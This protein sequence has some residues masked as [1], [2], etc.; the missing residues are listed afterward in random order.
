MARDLGT[1]LG[2]A[3]FDVVP[4]LLGFGDS[5]TAGI[6]NAFTAR[7]AVLGD[8]ME[9]A[10]KALFVRFTLP[11]AVA[12]AAN[13]AQFQALE[14][15]VL[16]TLTLF[17]TAPSLIDATFGE[18]SAGIR[19]VAEEV[20]GLERSIADGLYQTISAGV[21]S[22]GAFEFL[23]VAQMAATA[24][25][26]ADLTTAVNALTTGVNAF[27]L[28]WSETQRVSDI[29]FATV[30]RGKTTFGELG[31]DFGR[32]APLAFNAGVRIEETAAII[33]QLT[34]QG[35][36]TSEAVSFLRAAITGLLR[37]GDEMNEIFKAIGFSSAEAAVPVLGLQ[38]AFQ[39]VVDAARGSTSRL[40]E[41]IGTSEG[42][43]AVLGVTGESAAAF[44]SVLR[45]V[46]NSAGSTRRAFEI[47]D[48]SVSRLFGR[49]T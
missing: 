27:G 22:E 11:L 43:T 17:G 23:N 45:S 26:T 30:A 12:T 14:R 34:V 39:T 33:G 8:V 19:G 9:R 15:S 28:E 16:E 20:G 24:D 7:A 6:S 25:K 36:K 13:I 2:S 38:G 37:P 44:A 31:D 32:V 35:L 4:N 3:H 47:I 1:R 41:L 29:F 5:L 18:M 46:E 42:V 10:G 21:P 40:Q 49:M 48:G